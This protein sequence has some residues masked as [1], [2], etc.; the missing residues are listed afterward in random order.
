MVFMFTTILVIQIFLS[1]KDIA[2]IYDRINKPFWVKLNIHVDFI[3]YTF[4][5]MERAPFSD[6]SDMWFTFL[7]Y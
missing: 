6:S 5:I 3:C 2:K 1:V 4:P 7:A